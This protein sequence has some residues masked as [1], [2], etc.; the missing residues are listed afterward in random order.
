VLS[1]VGI[2]IY[3]DLRPLAVD[4]IAELDKSLLLTSALALAITSLDG[5]WRTLPVFAVSIA[6]CKPALTLDS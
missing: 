5:P 2:G 3:N 4:E 6:I 1:A